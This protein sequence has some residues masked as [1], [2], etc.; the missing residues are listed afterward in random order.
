MPSGWYVRK[1]TLKKFQRQPGD[2]PAMRSHLTKAKV[3]WYMEY[4]S[5]FIYTHKLYNLHTYILYFYL[6]IL[7]KYG[8]FFVSYNLCDTIFVYVIY[9]NVCIQ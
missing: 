6:L 3:V 7:R 2:I 1:E 9:K 4:V 5:I 8:Q